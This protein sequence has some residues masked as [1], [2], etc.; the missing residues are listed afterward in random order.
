MNQTMAS[1]AT[2]WWL[3]L[4]LWAPLAGGAADKQ[5]T[6]VD[7]KNAAIKCVQQRAWECAEGNWVFYL[8]V[9]PNDANGL[10]NYGIVLT[11]R[12]KYEAAIPQFEKA[13]DLGEG[14]YDLFAHYAD[15][16][17]KVGR[18]NE[19]IDWSY[20]ALTVVPSLVDVRGSL[21][22][23][24]VLQ[25]RQHEALALL[26][27]FDEHL[28]NR[29]HPPYF[30]GQ[31][32]SIESSIERAGPSQSA[33]QAALRLPK[34]GDHFYAPVVIGGARPAAFMV[35]TGAS[36]TTFSEELL[37]SSKAV[38]KVSR[39]DVTMKTA[40]GRL[41]K[42]RLVNIDSMK[43]GAFA[44]KNVSA[45][46]CRGCEPLLGQATLSQFDIQSTRTQGVEFLTLVPRKI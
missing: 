35:D 2:R 30:A 12:E 25:K 21:A 7:Y 38:F 5:Y 37:V 39:N 32:I 46:V 33:E 24:L 3:L 13:I 31:R 22:K 17:A 11:R 6:P 41:V 44:L 43:L 8:K 42:A 34:L 26:S 27:S 19:A 4:G 45:V 20:K 40:D 28:A 16:L 14:S 9:R 29:G 15:S 36:R 18:T 23:L 1:R 10:A